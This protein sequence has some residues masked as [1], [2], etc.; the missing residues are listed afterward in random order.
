MRG[1]KDRGQRDS[2]N[3]SRASRIL[4]FGKLD[5]KRFS[6]SSDDVFNVLRHCHD[7]ETTLYLDPPYLGNDDMYGF[8]DNP[9]FDHE[10]LQG[11]LALTRN[12]ILSYKDSPAIREL[13]SDFVIESVSVGGNAPA[14][15]NQKQSATG[16]ILILSREIAS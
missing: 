12:W 15:G 2:F 9:L 6:V 7:S 16:E 10:R 13:Y 8:G 4:A 14:M 3:L 5:K 11:C 1:V